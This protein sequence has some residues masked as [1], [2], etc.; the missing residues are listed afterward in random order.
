MRAATPSIDVTWD[1]VRAALLNAADS[2][3]RKG[4]VAE[5]MAA[6]LDKYIQSPDFATYFRRWQAAGVHVTPVH[7]YSP[8]P[9]T[10]QLGDHLWETH[11]ALP[12]VDLAETRQL[13]LLRTFAQ[14]QDEY[15][16]IPFDPTGRA[17]EYYLNNPM[18]SGVDALVLYCLIRRFRPSSIIE[19]GGGHSTRLMVDATR[20]NGPTRITTIEPHPGGLFTLGVLP[21]TLIDRRVQDL[22]LSLFE[23]L[24]ANDVLFIDSSHVVTIGGDVSYLFLEVLPCLAPGVLVHVHDVFLPRSQPREWVVD[25][26]RF[27]CE[28]D[29]LQAFLAF[30]RDFEIVLA[31]AYLGLR[32]E[33][34]LRDVFPRSPWWDRGG[35]FWL[36]RVDGSGS[37]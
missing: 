1:V 32:H 35:S 34:A 22:P 37:S 31:N 19:V 18:F 5:L 14:F 25:H 28:Q 16:A 33:A 11:T 9:D 26:M 29:L 8:I 12:G 15:D 17:G 6:V 2:P 13:A 20:R 21:V 23:S 36:R 7:F 3:E 4:D 10:S 30:N 27:W 24:R